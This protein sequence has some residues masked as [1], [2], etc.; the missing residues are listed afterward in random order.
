MII[1]II[2]FISSAVFLTFFAFSHFFFVWPDWIEAKQHSIQ[3][4]FCVTTTKSIQLLFSSQFEPFVTSPWH[5]NTKHISTQ[6][7]CIGN[8]FQFNFFTLHNS[9]RCCLSSSFI[10]ANLRFF[11]LYFAYLSY[12]SQCLIWHFDLKK[13][14]EI[15]W[16][17]NRSLFEISISSQWS[18]SNFTS[19]HFIHQDWL[20]LEGG[21]FFS[22]L[23][24]SHFIIP[25]TSN[26]SKIVSVFLI[27]IIIIFTFKANNTKVIYFQSLW[28]QLKHLWMKY[29]YIHK[30]G[31]LKLTI[32]VCSVSVYCGLIQLFTFKIHICVQL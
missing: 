19:L 14:P 18:H 8:K 1:I 25:H 12:V 30:F 6:V 32:N 4:F 15:E 13:Q 27:I 22:L 17:K 29:D 9:L 20:W 21:L 24:Q 5:G 26:N 11:F 2:I 28:R 3:L 31:I 16:R 7:H 23:I 10:L